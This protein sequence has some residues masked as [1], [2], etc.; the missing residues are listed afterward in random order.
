MRSVVG[1]SSR[2]GGPSRGARWL[3]LPVGFVRLRS[4]GG[5]YKCLPAG[6]AI[7]DVPVGDAPIA[8]APGDFSLALESPRSSVAGPGPRPWA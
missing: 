6:L 3:S 2:K 1:A 8:D 4:D 5:G 7:A